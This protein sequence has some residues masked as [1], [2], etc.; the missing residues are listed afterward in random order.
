LWDL[1]RF[2]N[3]QKTKNY[4]KSPNKEKFSQIGQKSVKHFDNQKI[5]A[6]S[7]SE[8]LQ[9][10]IGAIYAPPGIPDI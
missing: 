7:T 1:S 3:E 8:Q 9:Y 5:P 6:I 10:G 2:K 4:C